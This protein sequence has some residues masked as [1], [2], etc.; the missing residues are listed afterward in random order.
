MHFYSG[1]AT[2][3]NGLFLLFGIVGCV[4]II[5]MVLPVWLGTSFPTHRSP[6][7][8]EEERLFKRFARGEID[9]DEYLRHREVIAP[10]RGS[11]AAASGCVEAVRAWS[12][13]ARELGVVTVL[14]T[15]MAVMQLIPIGAV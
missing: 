9:D 13:L 3:W 10:G 4:V 5:S 6:R 8:D 15:F 2:G 1:E 7:T 11:S 12:R 14:V